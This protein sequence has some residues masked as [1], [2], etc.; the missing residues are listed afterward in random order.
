MMRM[1]W[2]SNFALKLTMII[3]GTQ[4]AV[5]SFIVLMVNCT[6]QQI[7]CINILCLWLLTS[8]LWPN[9]DQP[10]SN[11]Y[12]DDLLVF[13]HILIIIVDFAASLAAARVAA[14]EMETQGTGE[15]LSS[16]VIVFVLI[17]I[18]APVVAIIII[19]IVI[20]AEV[21]DLTLRCTQ[22][23][24]GIGTV[25]CAIFKTGETDRNLVQILK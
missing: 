12:Y 10:C 16:I 17:V 21:K 11:D 20:H 3:Q 23:P 25:Q 9:C 22:I 13:F 8:T 6:I 15:D 7:C 1:L 4:E 5:V 19:K 14:R 18:I 24:F 2:G